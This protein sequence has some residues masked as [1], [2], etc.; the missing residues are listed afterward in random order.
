[1]LNTLPFCASI[2][3]AQ[4]TPV[5]A[6]TISAAAQQQQQP[7]ALLNLNLQHAAKHNVPQGPP[8]ADGNVSNADDG[9]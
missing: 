2:I 8:A 5:V 9:K 6:A 1:M 7:Q 4:S 3:K